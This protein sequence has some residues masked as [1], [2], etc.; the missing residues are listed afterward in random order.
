MASVIKAAE[1][2]R[3][4]A[5]LCLLAA[6]PVVTF[7]ATDATVV[8]MII[9]MESRIVFVIFIVLLFVS[10]NGRAVLRLPLLM[11]HPKHK[12]LV[13]QIET[14]RRDIELR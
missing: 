2:T 5:R 3:T 13:C 12:H 14:W 9:A 1:R 4:H 6:K 7:C 10:D 11:H 8:N